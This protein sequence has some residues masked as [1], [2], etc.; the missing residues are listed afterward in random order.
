MSAKNKVVLVL[1]DALR[2]DYVTKEDS[3]FLYNFAKQNKYFKNVTQSRSFCERA[4]IFTGLSPRESGYF[5]AI[6]YCPE[7]SQYKDIKILEKLTF[8][9]KLFGKNRFYNGV[10]NRLMRLV[11][12]KK[13]ITMRSYS[14][15]LKTLKYFNLTEDKYDFRDENAFDGKG[16][17]FKDCK[18]NGLKIYYDSFTALNFTKSTSDESRLNMV[19]ENINSDFDLFLTYIGV[20]DSCAH[21]Y[22]PKSKEQKLEL[23]HLDQRLSIFHKN[24]ISENRD[25]KFIFL[26]DHGMADVHTHIDIAKE[27]NRIAA[28][29]SLKLGDDYVYFLDS[30][31]FRVWYLN[32]NAFGVIDQKLKNNTLLTSNGVFVDESIAKKEEIPFPDRRYGDTLWM[33][34]LGVLIFPDFFHAVKPYKGM[35]G[36]DVNDVSSKGTCILSAEEYEYIDNIKLT[37]IYD[38]LKRELGISDV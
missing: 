18:N 14:I 23:K 20:M 13:N 12:M 7:E 4:E 34:N 21:K 31:I 27:L 24:I 35:H 37:D 8:F 28:E 17:I 10:K 22:G 6:A 15:P 2:S 36:Y 19:E 16:N 32:S 3:P 30:T 11:T 25:A 33:A 29:N 5:T 26:G 1:I 38:I 9:E